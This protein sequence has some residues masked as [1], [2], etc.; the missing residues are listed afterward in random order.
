MLR[1]SLY[2]IGFIPIHKLRK[3]LY[4]GLGVKFEPGVVMHFKTEIR[5]PWNLSIGKRSIIGDNAILDARNYLTIGSNV[6]LSSN[7]SIYTMQHNHR[8]P[9]FG[10]EFDRPMHVKIGD[11][12]WIGSNV[13]ILPGVNIGEGAVCCAGSVVTKNVEPYTIMAGVPAK[14]IGER[15]HDLCYEFSGKAANIF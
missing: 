8:D 11:R 12:A 10:V 15:T 7:V 6:Q 14:K 5:A 4:S 2:W 1:Y 13:M 3:L 9:F